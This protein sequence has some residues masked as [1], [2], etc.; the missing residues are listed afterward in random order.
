[1][2]LHKFQAS[3][4]HAL[5]SSVQTH[6]HAWKQTPSVFGSIKEVH[7]CSTQNYG[8]FPPSVESKTLICV[9]T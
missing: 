5:T 7:E 3:H 6:T 2:C 1:M 9:R 4:T 8:A